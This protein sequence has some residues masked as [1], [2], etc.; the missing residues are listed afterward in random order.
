MVEAA[1]PGGDHQQP[2]TRT[3]CGRRVV[4][5]EGQVGGVLVDGEPLDVDPRLERRAQT[6]TGEGVHVAHDAV[7]SG[8]QVDAEGVGQLQSAVGGDHPG[9][10]ERGQAGGQS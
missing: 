6:R 9:Y 4:E 7:P 3:G 2:V 1:R 5:G 10:V 8:D